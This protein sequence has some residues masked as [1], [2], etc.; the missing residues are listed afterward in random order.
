MKI[1][2]AFAALLLLVP[3]RSSHADAA[4]DTAKLMEKA[5]VVTEDIATIVDTNKDACD[6]MGDK[7]NVY[8]DKQVPFFKQMKDA[9]KNMTDAQKKALTD[10]YADRMG[11]AVKKM[12]PGITNCQKNAKVTAAMAKATG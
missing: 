1:A 11:K 4:A 7:L 6:A 3:A 10:K 2:F 5:M 12:T 8:I 9:T